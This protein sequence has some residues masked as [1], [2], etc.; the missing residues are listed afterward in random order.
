MDGISSTIPQ[1][2]AL[3]E[4]TDSQPWVRKLKI[5]ISLF[6]SLSPVGT[7]SQYLLSWTQDT[8][9]SAWARLLRLISESIASESGWSRPRRLSASAKVTPI[10]PLSER[11]NK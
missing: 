5:K 9:L 10:T 6:F 7:A 3:V 11:K 8:A 2:S 1:L 4:S